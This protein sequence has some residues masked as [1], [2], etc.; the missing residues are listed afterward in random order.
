MSRPAPYPH[1][2]PN[3]HAAQ[4]QRAPVYQQAMYQHQPQYL[5]GYSQPGPMQPLFQA[6]HQ[7]AQQL[8][9]AAQQ[10]QYPPSFAQL[11]VPGAV[12]SPSVIYGDGLNGELMD[13][14]LELEDCDAM[15]VEP[16]GVSPTTVM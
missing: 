14:G 1:A 16:G 8:M 11:Q 12:S 3:P 7:A 2:A 13:D 10:Q 5:T 4:Y 6:A 9:Q 15:L